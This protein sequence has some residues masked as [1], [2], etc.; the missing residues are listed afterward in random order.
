MYMKTWLKRLLIGGE[1]FEMSVIKIFKIP[2]Q[3]VDPVHVE[4]A[5]EVGEHR[6]RG[7]MKK[8]H[9]IILKYGRDPL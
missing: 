3:A 1:T 7:K 8:L 2:A 9:C 5:G 4:G 6:H